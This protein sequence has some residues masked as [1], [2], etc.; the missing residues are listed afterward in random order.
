MVAEGTGW[1]SNGR[2]LERLLSARRFSS[3]GVAL[4]LR[5]PTLTQVTPFSLIGGEFDG[6]T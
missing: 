6:S 4:A 1:R 5:G 2:S 3:S